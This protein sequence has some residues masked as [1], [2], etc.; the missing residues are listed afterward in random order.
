MLKP[1]NYK[2]I[3]WDWNGTLIDDAWLFVDVMN[4]ILQKRNMHTITIEEYRNIFGFPIKNYYEKLGFNTKKESIEMLGLEFIKEYKKR[5]YEAV[6]FSMTEMILTQL[7]ALSIKQYILSACH[8]KLLDNHLKFYNLE[9]YFA[10]IMGVDNYFAKSKINKG[11][12][13]I[14]I[15]QVNPNDI[16][17][18][19]DTKHDFEVANK[20]GVDCLLISHGHHSHSQLLKTKTPIIKNLKTILDIFGID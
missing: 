3:I 20:I 12:E 19:G 9:K 6:L 15:M 2:H 4:N 18:I 17:F 5:Q 10:N 14:K 16:L 1:S 11:I 7:F 8:Q 13:L